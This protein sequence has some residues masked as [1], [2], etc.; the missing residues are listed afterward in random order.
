[1][2]EINEINFTYRAEKTGGQERLDVW[3][4]SRLP[5]YTRSYIQKLIESDNVKVNGKRVKSNYKLNT[6]DEIYAVLPE[7][8]DLDAAPQDIP[9]NIVYEDDDIIIINKSKNMVV[10]P[11][12]GNH[13]NT[14]VNALLYHCGD[15]LSDINGVI[16]PG[17]IHR[18]DKDTTG[19]ICVA[20]NNNAHLFLS[21]QL[22]DHTMKRTYV[23]LVEKVINE[24]AGIIDAPIGRHPA[25]RKKMAVNVKNGKSAV[26]EFKVLERF[27]KYTLVEAS[28]KTGRT[29]QIR[30][31]MAY[32][33]HP[34]CGDGL[35][36]NKL[37]LGETEGQ[38]LHAYKLELV[39]PAT[40]ENQVFYAEI[41]DYF[42]DILFKL[43]M[44]TY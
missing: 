18:I 10:H 34:V 20:K 15:R 42:N 22:K 25:D 35:Y 1:M 7:S 24:E 29:H 31:H 12:A 19:L 40:K 43:R 16:R 39:H 9:L 11:A 27:S 32:I 44:G 8:E 26:T 5:E 30:V 3:L 13:D 23:A 36:G 14:L 41:P 37:P 28:L 4:T 17:I 6:G 38:M 21:G 33:G 2:D